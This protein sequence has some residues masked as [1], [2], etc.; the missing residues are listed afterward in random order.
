MV[1]RQDE[2]NR[3][4]RRFEARSNEFRIAAQSSVSVI[5]GRDRTMGGKDSPRSACLANGPF[6][7]LTNLRTF[8]DCGFRL[9]QDEAQAIAEFKDL[10]EFSTHLPVG[11]KLGDRL[12]LQTSAIG[13]LQIV[14]AEDCVQRDG[15]AFC[16]GD[17]AGLF[18]LPGSRSVEPKEIAIGANEV[19]RDAGDEA[20][21]VESVPI[22]VVSEQNQFI[23]RVALCLEGH[24]AGDGE[25]ALEETREAAGPA[26]VTDRE[27]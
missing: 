16:F 8:V 9:E 22:E 3:D 26:G 7:R 25:L 21:A 17:C 12:S 18:D 13:K 11:E 19:L 10:S 2:L 20:F 27:D 6:D 5:I 1:G 14:I 24:H 15:G 4:P 23:D